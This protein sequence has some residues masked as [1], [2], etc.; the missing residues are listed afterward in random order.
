MHRGPA[1]ASQSTATELC[2]RR[3]RQKL[4]ELCAASVRSKLTSSNL[5]WIGALIELG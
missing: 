3:V 4:A 2:R 1:I 5:S